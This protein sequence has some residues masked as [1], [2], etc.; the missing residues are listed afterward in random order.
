MENNHKGF[1]KNSFRVFETCIVFFNFKGRNGKGVIYVISAGNGGIDDNCNADGYANSK[2]TI[3]IT[4]VQTGR[5][6][7]Y[8]EVCA[9]AL[10]ATYGGSHQDRYL[11]SHRLII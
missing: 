6:A 10:A 7:N 11:V 8:A 9:A 1:I 4:S 5:S 3:A 2:Y